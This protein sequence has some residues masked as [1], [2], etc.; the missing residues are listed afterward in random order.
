MLAPVGV[1]S[2]KEDSAPWTGEV[3]GDFGDGV[4]VARTARE[5]MLSV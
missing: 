4:G 5:V 2:S 3:F 1:L